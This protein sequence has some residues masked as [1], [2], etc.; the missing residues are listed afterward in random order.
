LDENADSVGNKI[1]EDGVK[2]FV[3]YSLEVTKRWAV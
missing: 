1:Y 2:A 3:D